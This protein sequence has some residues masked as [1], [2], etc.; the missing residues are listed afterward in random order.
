MTG[1]A[2]HQQTENPVQRFKIEVVSGVAQNDGV[3]LGMAVSNFLGDIRMHKVMGMQIA[4]PDKIP[5]G[6][7]RRQDFIGFDFKAHLT[8]LGDNQTAGALVSK[9]ISGNGNRIV[10]IVQHTSKI[11]QDGL[12]AVGI[13]NHDVLPIETCSIEDSRNILRK[14]SEA[15]RITTP[16]SRVGSGYA[17]KLTVF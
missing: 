6:Q 10:V 11:D 13:S 14:G 5:G 16:P 7:N 17:R 15:T 1:Q 4:L 12:R 3:R 9:G 8:E 2:L